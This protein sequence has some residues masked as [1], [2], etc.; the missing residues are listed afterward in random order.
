M[1]GLQ[2]FLAKLHPSF[3][4]CP[5]PCARTADDERPHDLADFCAECDVRRQLDFFERGA[6]GELRRRF[7]EGELPD[8]DELFAD[9][10]HVQ[11]LARSARRGRY[12]RGCSAL[13]ARL[14][15]IWRKEERRPERIAAWERAQRPKGGSGGGA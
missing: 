6:K 9:V 7:D 1:V 13:E 4:D 8:F 2:G 5:G 12:P 3:D 10:M 15:D 14:I 11:R